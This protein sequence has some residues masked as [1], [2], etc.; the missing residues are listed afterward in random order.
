MPNRDTLCHPDAK[1]RRNHDENVFVDPTRVHVREH[2]VEE[3]AR[4]LEKLNG[5]G[6][7]GRMVAFQRSLFTKGMRNM[8]LYNNGSLRRVV[9]EG[10]KE[11]EASRFKV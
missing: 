7:N 8:F 11:G 6:T 9:S 10:L 5:K 3:A 4:G 2:V 1:H